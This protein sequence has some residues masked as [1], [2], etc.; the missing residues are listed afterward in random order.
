MSLLSSSK[1]PADGHRSS[2]R[3]KSRPTHKAVSPYLVVMEHPPYSG[4]PRTQTQKHQRASSGLIKFRNLSSELEALRPMY[5][6]PSL[7]ITR[8]HIRTYLDA[9]RGSWSSLD[10]VAQVYTANRERVQERLSVDHAALEQMLK[11]RREHLQKQLAQA[12]VSAN[13]TDDDGSSGDES[14][15]ELGKT[16]HSRERSPHIPIE[17]EDDYV[18]H[19]GIIN[20]ALKCTRCP[21][22]KTEGIRSVHTTADLDA[23]ISQSL[24]ANSARLISLWEKCVPPHM[25]TSDSGTRIKF[26]AYAASRTRMTKAVCTIARWWLRLQK[27]RRRVR[28]PRRETPRKKPQRQQR[29]FAGSNDIFENDHGGYD[30]K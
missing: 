5:Q 25:R 18:D 14:D 27:R 30:M 6:S 12:K 21:P 28:K 22:T 16:E 13:G 10:A 11:A 7:Q 17:A 19:I 15:F 9:T 3:R 29:Y 23:M 1:H 20:A 24:A 8:Q 2:P 4:L 26:M